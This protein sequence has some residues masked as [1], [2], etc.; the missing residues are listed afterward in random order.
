MAKE[1]VTTVAPGVKRTICHWG[2]V[3]E[4][5]KAD[6]LRALLTQETWFPD[7]TEFNKKGQSLRHKRV[8][9]EGRK[10]KSQKVSKHWYL[11]Y[12]DYCSSSCPSFSI[13]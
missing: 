9:V 12:V 10:I 5:R 8:E 13:I 1:D 11:V 3:L 4:G 7:G 6:L 2:Y